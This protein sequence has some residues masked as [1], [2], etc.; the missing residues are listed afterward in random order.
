MFSLVLLHAMFR[1][2]PRYA[3]LLC[4]C[5][6]NAYIVCQIRASSMCIV[7]ALCVYVLFA[8]MHGHHFLVLY[9]V[10]T[11]YCKYVASSAELYSAIIMHT[12]IF[13]WPFAFDISL[14]S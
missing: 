3:V 5:V 1:V 4:C 12:T 10:C 6:T 2:V 7:F 8:C 11:W 14:H 13:V 9:C